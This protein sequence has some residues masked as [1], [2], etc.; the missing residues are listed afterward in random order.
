MTSYVPPALIPAIVLTVLMAVF[1]ALPTTW[2]DWMPY[3][4]IAIENGQWWR[5]LT[6]NFIHLGW[7]HLILNGCG[8]LVIA[9]LFA[10]DRRTTQWGSDLL[11]CSL[12]TGIGLYLFNPEVFWCVGLSGA[13][14][15]LFAI[16]AISWIVAGVGQGRWLLA[17]LAVKLSWEHFAGE[18][19]FSGGIIGGNVITDAHAWGTIGGLIAFAADQLWQRAKARL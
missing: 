13:L 6:G 16:G 17:G 14:H 18:M 4:R 7:G 1:Q 19:P 5:L 11:I 12:A 10:E 3:E 15:G 2:Q 8:L 9:W